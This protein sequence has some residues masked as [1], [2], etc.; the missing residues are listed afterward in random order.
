[1]TSAEWRLAIASQTEDWRL[2]HCGLAIAAFNPQLSNPRWNQSSITNRRCNRH[3]AVAN[4]QLSAWGSPPDTRI[5]R[6]DVDRPRLCQRTV[7][8]FQFPV[9]SFETD[10]EL[11]TGN[12]L[13]PAEYPANGSFFFPRIAP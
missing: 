13:L 8:S 2:A 10:W 5:P 11:V 7:S 12:W 1:L 6:G 9:A 3:S 4:R